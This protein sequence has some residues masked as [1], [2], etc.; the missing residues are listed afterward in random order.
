[1]YLF[2]LIACRINP[3]VWAGLDKALWM[4]IWNKVF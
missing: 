1:M 3:A 2:I 4:K